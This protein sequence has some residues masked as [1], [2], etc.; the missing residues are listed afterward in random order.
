MVNVF[1]L[2]LD[3][4]QILE[5]FLAGILSLAV[6]SFF[7]F[8]NQNYICEPVPAFWKIPLLYNTSKTRGSAISIIERICLEEEIQIQLQKEWTFSNFFSHIRPSLFIH[9]NA[10]L[11][12]KIILNRDTGPKTKLIILLSP[13]SSSNLSQPQPFLNILWLRI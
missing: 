1:M 3:C 10:F 9:T 2:F 13:L 5:S 6:Y 8:K 7:S 12:I 4:W 11:H